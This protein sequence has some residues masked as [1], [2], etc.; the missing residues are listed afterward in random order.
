M[1]W[2][3]GLESIL[4]DKK[5][6]LYSAIFLGVILLQKLPVLGESSQFNYSLQRSFFF[7]LTN[8][9]RNYSVFLVK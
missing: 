9:Y 1:H 5:V 6:A 8:I 2:T 4:Q 3:R 7:L